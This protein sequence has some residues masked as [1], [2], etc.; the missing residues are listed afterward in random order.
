MVDLKILVTGANGLLGKLLIE[1][2]KENFEI[3]ALVRKIPEDP[4]LGV[5]YH[6]HDLATDWSTESLP[7]NINTI[8]HLAQSELFREFPEH[9][10]DVYN[11]NLTSTIK[12]LDYGRKN[13]VKKFVFASTGGIYDS[14]KEPL[15]ESSPIKI[16][17]LL[18][19]YFAT[20]LC[21]E[22]LSQNYNGYFDIV[23]IR[24]FFM[25]GRGQKRSMLMPRLIDNI[26]AGRPIKISGNG[27]IYINPVHVSDVVNVLEKLI[28][29]KGSFTFNVAGPEI[30]NLEQIAKIIGQKLGKK[31]SFVYSNE[32]S[33]NCIA[34]IGYLK[35]TL[36]SPLASLENKIEE[37]F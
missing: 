4:T 18:G 2:L 33:N 31:P 9:S 14:S 7:L 23:L 3:H 20:K 29:L 6:I 17:S 19:N 28:P 24:I 11:V 32:Q 15:I 16:S 26:L 10:L 21:S 12:L 5:T 34:D 1:A 27:G 36:Y 13:G 25:Y 30:L 8:F 22:I 37:L 35:N